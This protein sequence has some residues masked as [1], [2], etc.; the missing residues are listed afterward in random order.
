MKKNHMG[1]VNGLLNQTANPG[2]TM[3]L[4]APKSQDLGNSMAD[5]WAQDD[6]LAQNNREELD[7]YWSQ[8]IEESTWVVTSQT[9]EIGAAE[10]TLTELRCM[11]LSLEIDLDP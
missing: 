11:V 10:M 1:E 2:L 9:A 7:K 8:Q 5:V 3:D 6:K 4:D